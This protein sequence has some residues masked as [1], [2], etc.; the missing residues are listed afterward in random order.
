MLYIIHII[1]IQFIIILNSTFINSQE[2]LLVNSD[3]I[4]NEEEYMSIFRIP[5]SKIKAY[6]LGGEQPTD[7]LSNA[8]DYN[9]NNKWISFYKNGENFISSTGQKIENLK[10]NVEFIFEKI[11]IIDRLVYQAQSSI[12][13]Y[14]TELS[15]YYSENENDKYIFFEKI[16]SISTKKKVMFVFSKAI[17]CKK[18]KLEYSEMY[19]EY[20]SAVEFQF[21]QAENKEI[22]KIFDLYSDYSHTVVK[23]EIT[24]EYLNY[25]DEICKKNINYEI[26]IFPLIDRAKKFMTGL[27]IFDPRKEFSTNPNAS[28]VI[29]RNGELKNYMNNKLKMIWAGTNKQPTGIFGLTGEKIT[30]YLSAK[31]EDK[32]PKIRF[33]QHIGLWSSWNS[34]DLNLKIGKNLFTFPNFIN[35]AYSSKPIPGGPIYIINPYNKNE[36]SE[37]VKIYI[38]GGYF[39]PLYIKG[40]NEEDFFNSLSQYIKLMEFNPNIYMDLM[41]IWGDRVLFTIDAKKGY[42]IYR[43][44]KGPSHSIEVWDEYLKYLFKFNG[45]KYEKNE[46][47][48]DERNYWANINFRHT[49]PYG[50][51]Y[52]INEHVGIFNNAWLNSATYIYSVSSLG[53]GF[54]HEIGHMMDIAERTISETTNNMEAKYDECYLRRICIRGEYDNN[55]LYLTPDINNNSLR[56]NNEPYWGRL[57]FLLWWQIET[58]FPGYWGKLDNMYRYNNTNNI[59][60]TEKQVYFSSIITGVNMSYYYERYAFRFQSSEGYFIYYNTSQKFKEMMQK[61][62]KDGIIENKILKFWYLNGQS[63]IY[64]IDNNKSDNSSCYKNNKNKINIIKVLKTSNSYSIFLPI[65]TCL[66]HLGYEIYENDKVINFTMDIIFTDKIKYSDDYIPKYK[67]RAYDKLLE[68]TE[69]SDSKSYEKENS[70]VCIFNDIYYNSIA[71]AIKQIPDYTTEAYEIILKKNTYEGQIEI[72]ADIIIKLDENESK[73]II[74]FKATNGCIFKVNANKNLVLIGKNETVKLVIDGDNIMQ[75]G[76]LIDNYGILQAKYV[77]FRNG[78]NAQNGG[79]INNLSTGKLYIYDSLFENNYSLNGGAIYINSPSGRGEII[80]DIFIRNTATSSGGSIYNIGLISVINCIIQNNEATINGAGLA[81]VAGGVITIT[82]TQIL[83]NKANENGGGI[84]IDGYTTIQNTIIKHNIAL[85]NGG[86]IYESTNNLKR[87][88]ICEKNTII[89]NNTAINGSGVYIQKGNANYNSLIIYD[90]KISN[91]GSNTYLDNN[92]IILYIKSKNNKL[93]GEIY[94][95][96]AASI[97]LE[98]EIFSLYQENK[99][100][101]LNSNCVDSKILLV[102]LNNF[103]IT[104]DQLKIFSSSLGTLFLPKNTEIWLKVKNIILTYKSEENIKEVECYYGEIITINYKCLENKYV[105]KITDNNGKIYNI[106]DKI[107]IYDSLTLIIEEKNAFGITLDFLEN[108]IKYYSKPDSYYYLPL[109]NEKPDDDLFISYWTD[110]EGNLIFDKV[111][112]TNDNISFY[113]NYE[114]Y[115]YIKM[116]YQNERLFYNLT[117]YNTS[118]IIPDL[119]ISIPDGYEFFWECNGEK[120]LSGQEII[121]NKNIYFIGSLTEIEIKKEKS[122]FSKKKKL[123]KGLL[124]G[125]IIGVAILIIAIILIIILVRYKKKSDPESNNDNEIFRVCKYGGEGR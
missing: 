37:E 28:K 117:E 10:N 110:N 50:E 42:E 102:Q 75:S 108:K 7:P 6:A 51:A 30:I 3:D 114:G 67:I 35:N 13:G 105:S 81:N 17:T 22:M 122:K 96:S 8:F 55:L 38:D 49:Q 121:I 33:S 97:I 1:Y 20:A 29:R 79:A 69:L 72:N 116:D 14:P 26:E 88:L 19:G 47:F 11:V 84:F 120:Y 125:I 101:I 64:N 16:I 21:Y 70:E 36:Q 100:L 91:F 115:F 53:W 107:T 80:N 124:I 76:S 92:T 9:W 113:A 94:K 25:I 48:Y 71:D 27:Y 109:S 65:S 52:A 4:I 93:E 89:S 15:I 119:N 39:F 41:E 56:Y 73:E 5:H 99:P 111:K 54:A 2:S 61:L 82:N 68:Y 44:G 95:N 23:K 59:V 31:N 83:N 66:G 85:G 58:L 43:D 63:Y 45:V 103:F 60:L 34:P 74:I 78:K 32:L 90:N 77:T 40:N 104:D 87:I 106:G 57:N 62:V 24:F 98:N 18:I 86:G 12:L 118:F 112:V 46:Q 123:N